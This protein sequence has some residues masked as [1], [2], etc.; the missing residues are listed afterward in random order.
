[1]KRPRIKFKANLTRNPID[2][3]NYKKERNI[4][5]KLN[6]Q[7]KIEYFQKVS[8]KPLSHSGIHINC[9]FQTNM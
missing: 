4:A 9:I 6:D 3:K 2:I 5:V 7:S 1:M 8:A